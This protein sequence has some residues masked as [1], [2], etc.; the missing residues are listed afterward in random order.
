MKKRPNI[1]SHDSFE[2]IRDTMKRPNLRNIGAEEREGS[3][4]QG[5]KI[6]STKS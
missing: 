4:V 3:Q 6:F 5:Q 2:E 1:K